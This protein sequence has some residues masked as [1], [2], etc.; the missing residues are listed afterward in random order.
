M[1]CNDCDAFYVGQT[2][3]GFLKRFNE[4]K[5][6]TTCRNYDTI[7]SSFAKHL[8][9]ENHS[10]TDF[11][12]NLKPLHFCSKG[13]Y[14]NTLEEFEVYKAFR[15]TNTK[16]HILNDQLLFKYNVLYNTALRY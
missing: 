8:I 1:S 9:N 7:K 6:P 16:P 12:T 13:R 15:D 14:M 3:R 11:R 2:G 4:H 10:Y 5:L